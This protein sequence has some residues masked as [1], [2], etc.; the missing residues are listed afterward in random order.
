MSSIRLRLLILSIIPLLCQCAC[1]SPVY[2]N[3]VKEIASWWMPAKPGHIAGPIH[4]VGTKGLGAYLITTSKGDILIDGGMPSS[5]QTIEK[6]IR[7]LG[8]DPTKLRKILISHAHVDHVGTVAYFKKLSGA[9]VY[10]MKE[11]VPGLE[12][13]GRTCD[14]IGRLP[15]ARYTP[16]KVE[17][18]L[19]DGSRVTLG[20]ITLTAIHTPGH[21][22]GCTTWTTQ[23]KDHGKTYKVVFAGS[24]SVNPGTK[25]TGDSTCQP[26]LVADYEKSFDRLGK[27]KPQIFLCAHSAFFDFETKRKTADQTKS[28]DAYED[29]DGYRQYLHDQ[30][31]EFLKHIKKQGA[32]T[33]LKEPG[34]CQ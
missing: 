11:D 32:T 24:T 19:H 25:L 22:P 4:Y 3:P 14:F 7:D 29:P 34:C 13:G 20:G 6:S 15:L 27:L 21:T 28:A 31:C 17:H 16:V 5:A 9:E 1:K 33:Q 8:R 30:R 12:S 23:V 10:A 2:R 18:P 26:S